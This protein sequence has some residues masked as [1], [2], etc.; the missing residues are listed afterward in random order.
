MSRA[1][2]ALASRPEAIERTR[3][4]I[5]GG[6]LRAIARHGLAKMGMSD[7]SDAAGVSRGTLYRY[8]PTR[9]ALLEDLAV[10]VQEK[11]VADLAV[12]LAGRGAV[13]RRL[14]TSIRYVT[15]QVANDPA[16]RRL[17]ET[18]PAFV[19]AYARERR[20]AIRALVDRLLGPLV[21]V[22]SRRKVDSG[23]RRD[24]GEWLARA[25]VS[26]VL[27]PDPD[28]DALARSL[29]RVLTSALDGGSR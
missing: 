13:E 20:P 29:H 14:L 17:I 26:A 28:G 1:A 11:L 21:G 18:E 23:L 4:R 12:A 22:A 25:L 19:L 8:F 2:P 9:E 24:V 10:Y 6:A 7:V 3:Q 5:L 15:T 16:I 27:F